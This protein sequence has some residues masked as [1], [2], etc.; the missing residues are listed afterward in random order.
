MDKQGRRICWDRNCQRPHQE[1]NTQFAGP[2][3]AVGQSQTME[4]GRQA[5]EIE[6]GKTGH[7]DGAGVAGSKWEGEVI[8]E[9]L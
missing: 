6:A 7:G 9:A 5:A 2:E 3:Y 8:Q 1:R 4:P